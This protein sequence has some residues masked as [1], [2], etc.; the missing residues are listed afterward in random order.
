MLLN[1][2]CQSVYELENCSSRCYPP[3]GKIWCQKQ[4]IIGE[5]LGDEIGR[6]EIGIL[7][8]YSSFDK[9]TDLFQSSIN[10]V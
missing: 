9:N 8:L 5:V 1:G 3:L 2:Y 10:V 7:L 4:T 6:F